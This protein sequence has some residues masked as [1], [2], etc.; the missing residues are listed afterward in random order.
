VTTAGRHVGQSVMRRED[1]R[2]L[3]GHARYVANLQV[4]GALHAAF[5]R[6]PEARG[7]I[8]SVDTSRARRH[9]G[10][11]A[12][13]TA[14]DLNPRCAAMTATLYLD[15]PNPP[16]RPLADDDVRFVGHSIALVVAESEAIA[17]DAAELVEVNIEPSPAAVDL[18]DARSDRVVVH[19]ELGTNVAG[20]VD[21]TDDETWAAVTRSAAHV[22]TRT[23]EHARAANAPMEGRAILADW[24]P[25]APE[26]SIWISSQNAHE[27]RATTARML[28]LPEHRIRVIAPDVGGGFGQKIFVSPDEACIVLAAHTL[29]RPVRWIEA[30][31]ENLM[32][33][34]HARHD[35]ATATV[36]LDAD[37]RILGLRVDEHLEDVG[38]FPVGG[39]SSSL[40][41]VRR[42]LPGPYR[43]PVVQYRG[44]ALYTNTGGRVAYRGPWLMETVIREQLL[45]HAARVA[46][47]DPLELRRRNTLTAGDLPVTTSTGA[48][49]RNISPEV[50]LERVAK[51]IGYDEIRRRQTT[52]R[53]PQRR[54]GV[55]LAAFIEPTGMGAGLL[56]SEQ[57]TLRI[58]TTGAVEVAMGTGSTGNSLETTIP[59]VIAQHLGCSFDDVVFR[60]GDTSSAPWGHGSGGSRAAVVAGGAALEASVILRER[61]VNIAADLLE[62]APGDLDVIESTVTVR[63]TPA[64]SVSLADVARRAYSRPEATPD[65]QPPGLEVAVRYRPDDP[66]T[67]SN[68]T[69]ACVVEVDVDTGAVSIL[70]YAVSEDCGTMINPMVVEGQIAGGVVQGIAGALFEAFHYS[71]DGTP[72]T[73]GFADYLVP[74]AAELPS[75]DFDHVETPS[76]TAGGFKG[77]GEGGAIAGPA[78]VANAVCDAIGWTGPVTTLPLAPETVWRY[79]SS[80]SS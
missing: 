49:V 29:A 9:P 4:P 12:V 19:R 20:A 7:Q 76:A 56:G 39:T 65:G 15:A 17:R 35:R 69:H 40:S 43:I 13:L 70:R 18:D 66:Y 28:Q 26:L 50:T 14:R 23:F 32:A 30:R 67:F 41:G 57:A 34:G 3:T 63:G 24:D 53:A 47:L 45:D 2:M 37:G 55:G 1:R 51:E 68:A 21:T 73:V 33:A 59:Q 79:A 11:V 71:A 42:G 36:A 61:V 38:A 62:A 75:F 8:G 48:H 52:H 64:R 46:G 77:M 5:V 22:V 72:R 54:I 80:G 6:S 25:W 58:S 44:I 31:E 60:Q 78:A 10:V 74:S 27:V 16:L